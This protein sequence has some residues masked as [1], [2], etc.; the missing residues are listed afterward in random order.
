M[1]LP[2]GKPGNA[3]SWPGWVPWGSAIVDMGTC[4]SMR[5]IDSG[6]NQWA[7][8]AKEQRK[9]RSC[10]DRMSILPVPGPGRCELVEELALF[11]FP[12]ISGNVRVF[13]HDI[14]D[15]VVEAVGGFFQRLHVQF[16]RKD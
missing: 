13:G 11:Q 1:R 10:P 12:N 7:K 6:A 2:R 4:A 8:R 9:R 5:A 14:I 3:A 15:L 16:K